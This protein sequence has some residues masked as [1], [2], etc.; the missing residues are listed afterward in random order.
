MNLFDNLR[1]VVA[2]A[3]SGGTISGISKY[4]KEQNDKIQIVGAD[5]FGSILAQPENLN[6][7]DI[8]DY[9]VEGIGYD[10]VP[11]VLDEKIN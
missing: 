5:P 8:T 2:G 3:G 10:F 6:K 4:L 1:A 7:T 11:Q 9:K